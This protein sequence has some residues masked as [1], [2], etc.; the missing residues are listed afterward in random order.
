MQV[1][2]HEPATIINEGSIDYMHL[3]NESLTF[4]GGVPSDMHHK[5]LKH[6]HVKDG[7]SFSGINSSY[8]FNI[9]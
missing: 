7:V 1:D 6:Y 3:K 5:L 4:I 8:E 9:L 2:T